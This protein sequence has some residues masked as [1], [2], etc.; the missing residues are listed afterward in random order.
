MRRKAN[1]SSE[2]TSSS[3]LRLLAAATQVE[4]STSRMTRELRCRGRLP[5][6]SRQSCLNASPTWR[7][8]RPDRHRRVGKIRIVEGPRS[9]EDQVRS[10]L[11]LAKERSA[12]SWAEPAMHSIP[13]IGHTREIAQPPYDLERCGAKAGT[14]CSTA[15]TQIL[16]IAAP[17]HPRGDWRFRTL[18]AN[19][20]A[21]TPACD[22][23][24]VLQAHERGNA[25][26]HIVRLPLASSGCHL[27]TPRKLRGSRRPAEARQRED[28]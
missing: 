18:P 17:A 3:R 5:F 10:C 19:R 11:G 27:M 21:K 24:C 4:R 9:D 26:S 12:A 20:T 1:S 6:Q 16:A 15:C 8:G 25:S 28:I 14:N 13:T 23:H 7:T 2:R 22:C